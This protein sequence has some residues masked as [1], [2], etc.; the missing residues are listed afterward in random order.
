MILNNNIE[1]PYNKFPPEGPVLIISKSIVKSKLSNKFSEINEIDI[2]ANFNQFKASSNQESNLNLI[3]DE[4]NIL[5]SR[6]ENN[7]NNNNN[8]Q[9]KDQEN[10]GYQTKINNNYTNNN[11][12]I[13]VNLKNN[14]PQSTKPLD[15]KQD[16]IK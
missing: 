8:Y 15:K 2:K 10:S 5:N 11:K 6:S 4:E 3:Q 16:N 13:P 9:F 14:R 1:A 7:G 12:T